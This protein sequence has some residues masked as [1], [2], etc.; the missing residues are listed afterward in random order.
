MNKTSEERI[1]IYL[2]KLSKYKNKIIKEKYVKDIIEKADIS[3]ADI[4]NIEMYFYKVYDRAKQLEKIGKL[5]DSLRELDTVYLYSLHSNSIFFSFFSFYRKLVKRIYSKGVDKRLIHLSLQAREFGI[6]NSLDLIAYD[7]AGKLKHK[8]LRLLLNFILIAIISLITYTV[9]MP[10]IVGYY[11]D[12]SKVS[13]IKIQETMVQGLPSVTR[14]TDLIVESADI[15]AKPYALYSV[16][17]EDAKVLVFEDAH[18]YQLKAGVISFKKPIKKISYSITVYD[19]LGK[20]IL[21]KV[22]EKISDFHNQW[23]KGVYVPI[24][25]TYNIAKDIKGHPKKMV[26][27]I[28]SIEF[29]DEDN[30]I[31]NVDLE[32]SSSV[33]KFKYLGNYFNEDFGIY[34][35]NSFIEVYNNLK[36]TVKYLEIELAYF[37]KDSQII[38]TLRRKLISDS[39]SFLK[40]YSRQSFALKTVFPKEIYPNI[41]E[42]LSFIKILNVFTR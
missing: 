14:M 15:F 18:T 7:K 17:V 30:N 29:F 13:N 32:T 27:N 11:K 22:F 16:E 21:N 35:A 12:L 41:Q 39:N 26:L 28:T 2:S 9:V 8:L 31:Y 38:R 42:E 1:K 3:D 4:E 40:P 6:V 10:F 24:D 36:D 34:E 5:N 33:L 19:D 23:R 37:T 25:F 20:P